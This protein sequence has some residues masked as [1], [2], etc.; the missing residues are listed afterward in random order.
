MTLPTRSYTA[1]VVATEVEK[2]HQ[3]GRMVGWVQGG[4]AVILGGIA[5]RLLGWIPAIAVVGLHVWVLY[6]LVSGSQEEP[7]ES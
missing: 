5:L 3:R 4:G 6:K 2:A 1:K 7:S